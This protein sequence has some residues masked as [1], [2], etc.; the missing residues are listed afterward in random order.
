M[1][2][3]FSSITLRGLTIPNRIAVAPMCQYIADDGCM[4]DWHLMHLGQFAVSGAGLVM[5]EM[6]DV[7]PNGRIGPYCV[8]LYSD[9]CEAAMRRVV[10]F[11]RKFGGAKLGIQL[12]H[13][14]RKSSVLPPW[15][16]RRSVPVSQG[17]WRPVGPS[18]ISVFADQPPPRELS[19][20]DIETLVDAF[21][22]AVRRADRLGFDLIELHGAHGYLIHQFLSPISNQRTDEYGGSL[23]NRMR[24]PLDVFRS[25]RA[26]WPSHK[27]MGAKISARDW[28]SGGWSMDDTVEYC[29]QLRDLGCDFVVVSSGGIVWDEKIP[30][31]PGFQ[32]AFAEQIRR[33]VGV[34]VCAVGLITD[35]QQANDIV[36]SGAADMVALARGMLW[37]PRWSWHAADALG[38]DCFVPNQYTRARPQLAHDTFAVGDAGRSQTP[39]RAVGNA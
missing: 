12:A 10:E 4:H 36:S 31:A 34:P 23:E 16:G 32:V 2:S 5:T 3:L 1:S 30:T 21:V 33:S 27:P 6:T 14:G 28:C 20:S 22:A 19:R 37:D 11:C 39:V 17:G 26:A 35:A 8:G 15:Q 18:P 13:A 38:S 29:R 9:E 24:F 7:E 25:M